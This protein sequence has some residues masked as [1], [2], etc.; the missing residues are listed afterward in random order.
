M[1]TTVYEM[2]GMHC[3]GCAAVLQALLQ[4][5]EGAREAAVSYPKREARVR[6]DPALSSE[7]ALPE[8]IGGLGDR[9]TAR[10]PD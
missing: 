10:T 5:S 9:I 8:A 6:H 7:E 1:R 3:E 4:R 2:E